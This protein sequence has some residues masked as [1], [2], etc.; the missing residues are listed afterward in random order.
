[1]T[2]P[3]NGEAVLQQTATP[4]L[5][6]LAQ[7]NSSF[8]HREACLHSVTVIEQTPAGYFHCARERRRLNMARVA[9]LL[10]CPGLSSWETGFVR[11]LSRQTKFSPR[12]EA[13]LGRIYRQFF[14]GPAT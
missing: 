6:G 7:S 10:T 14:G 11:S 5:T 8:T 2:P 3:R 13:V 4:K 1:M 9:R 12:Q